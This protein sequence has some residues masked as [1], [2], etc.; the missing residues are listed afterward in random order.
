MGIPDFDHQDFEI[1]LNQVKLEPMKRA[2]DEIKPDLWFTNIRK[3]QTPF[4]NDL[5][6][7]SYPQER[8]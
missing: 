3:D 6:I 1:F 2:F 4:R 8:Y 7:L 5:D